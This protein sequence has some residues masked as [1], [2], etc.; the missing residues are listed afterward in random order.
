MLR[1][2]V[3]RD[4]SSK[5]AQDHPKGPLIDVD[6]EERKEL[7]ALRKKKG[8]TQQQLATKAG[9]TNGT[10]SNFESGKSK[11]LRKSV[12]AAIRRALRAAALSD[13]PAVDAAEAKAFRDF[14]E[15]LVDLTPD[16]W[17]SLGPVIESLRKS[18]QSGSK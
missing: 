5:G 13:D 8:W 14:V 7:T 4:P 15:N 3:P 17:R 18:G 6:P 2:D 11:Q 10:I 9:L 1:L 12:Y 16:Q